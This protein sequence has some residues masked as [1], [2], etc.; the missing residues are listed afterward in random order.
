MCCVHCPLLRG[1]VR[2]GTAGTLLESRS[3]QVSSRERMNRMPHQSLWEDSSWGCRCLPM[4]DTPTPCELLSALLVAGVGRTS[5]KPSR[6]RTQM[7]RLTADMP[8]VDRVSSLLKPAFSCAI[9]I[10]L[11]CCWQASTSLPLQHRHIACRNLH[12]PCLT[13]LCNGLLGPAALTQH[14]NH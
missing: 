2:P 4:L 9:C 10:D 11:V 6:V 14:R 3:G 13:V 8:Q 5:S 1:V 7:P 12:P